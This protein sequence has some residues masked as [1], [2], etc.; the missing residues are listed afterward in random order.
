MFKNILFQIELS[1]HKLPKGEIPKGELTKGELPKEELPKGELPKGELLKG[2]IPKEEKRYYLGIININLLSYYSYEHSLNDNTIFHKNV[3]KKYVKNYIKL[4]LNDEILNIYI[5]GENNDLT[6]SEVLYDY[7]IDERKLILKKL[8]IIIRQNEFIELQQR[9]YKENDVISNHDYEDD[10]YTQELTESII[11]SKY[12]DAEKRINF[13]KYIIIKET[14]NRDIVNK[15]KLKLLTQ[16]LRKFK[17]MNNNH[18]IIKDNYI[19]VEIDETYDDFEDYYCTI[20]TI[21]TKDD[22]KEGHHTIEKIGKGGNRYIIQ[23]TTYIDGISDDKYSE[24][25]F[26]YVIE[27]M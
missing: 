16:L 3:I 8:D 12:K 24:S 9:I 23:E 27:N 5:I 6:D 1:K 13:F 17:Y 2:E 22:K 7:I 21:K 26:K 18:L 19:F 15:Y 11:E 20:Y 10:E 25:I 4:W 14:Y